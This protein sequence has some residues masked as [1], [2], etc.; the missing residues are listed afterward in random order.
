MPDSERSAS[1]SPIRSLRWYICGLLFLVT[2]INY[3]DR[4]SLG[5]MAPILQQSIGW[6]DAEF[7][8]INFCFALSYAA[9][10]PVAGRIIDRVGV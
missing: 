8:W 3:I 1:T 5:A 10:F 7:G 4:V 2:F 9:M 6:D